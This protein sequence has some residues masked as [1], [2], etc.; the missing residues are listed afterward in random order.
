MRR[1]VRGQELNP[2]VAAEFGNGA[3]WLLLLL[4]LA[5]PAKCR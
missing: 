5:P 3:K 4:L 1:M 2:Y